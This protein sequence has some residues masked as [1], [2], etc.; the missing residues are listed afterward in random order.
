MYTIV[1][2]DIKQT[3]FIDHMIISVENPKEIN[4]K[5]TPKTNKQLYREQGYRIQV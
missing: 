4:K 2:K 5:K 3:L 1:K